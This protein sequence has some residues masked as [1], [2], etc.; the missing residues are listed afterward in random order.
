MTDEPS[1][2][3]CQTA[4]A[5]AS[6]SEPPEPVTRRFVDPFSADRPLKDP[7]RFAGRRAQVDA[8]V[9]CLFQTA[10]GAGRHTIITGDRGIGKSSLLQQALQIAEGQP[11]L[12]ERL[13]IELGLPEGNR[14]DFAT[15]FHETNPDETLAGLVDNLLTN[16]Q[17]RGANLLKGWTLSFNFKNL[18]KAERELG[19]TGETL[20]EL[21]DAT[22]DQLKKA[23]DKTAGVGIL[24]FIDELDR[25]NPETRAATFFKLVSEELSRSGVENV[26]FF[27]A[28]ITGAVQKLEEEHASVFRVF[29]DIPLPRLTLE[30]TREIITSGFAAVGAQARDSV[31]EAVHEQAAGFP[32]PVHLLGSSLLT[33]ADDWADV[34]D[35]DYA[36]AVERVVVDVRRNWLDNRLKKAGG[37]KYQDILKGMAAHDDR[38]VPLKIIEKAIGQNQNQF[39]AN[40]GVLIEREVIDRVDVGV[41]AFRDPLLREYIRKFGVWGVDE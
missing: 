17:S 16:F 12:T 5:M 7:D 41:Y 3:G 1:R 26:G 38:N 25:I 20:S 40:M 22:V 8:V 37:G 19:G 21:V 4:C 6:A 32:E 34:E 11:E 24:L 35:D 18:V 27:A 15:G 29:R 33:V 14:F 2:A 36:R 13:G 9:D 23:R 30:E 10:C 31:V 39:S 28:G